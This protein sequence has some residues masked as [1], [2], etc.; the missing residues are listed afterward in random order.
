MPGSVKVLGIIGSPREGGNTDTLVTTVLHGAADAGAAT[1]KLFIG[2][3]KIGFCT[4]CSACVKTGQCFQ[5]DGMDELIPLMKEHQVWVLGTPVYWWGATAQ[6]KVFIDRWFAPWAHPE[7]R[8]LF[9]NRFAVV[10][11]PLGA[12]DVAVARHATG[13]FSDIFAHLGIPIVATVVA[14]HVGGYVSGVGIERGADVLKRPEPLEAAY[15]AGQL[16]VEKA[17]SV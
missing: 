15:D 14:P 13:M 17:S 16:A 3:S 6:M 10:V 7:T 12:A 8:K 2:R 5:R 9:G 1:T 11:T 4:S